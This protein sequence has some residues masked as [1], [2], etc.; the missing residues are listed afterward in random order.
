LEEL[1]NVVMDSMN[2]IG[3]DEQNFNPLNVA[4]L[5]EGLHRDFENIGEA[6]PIDLEGF[7]TIGGYDMDDSIPYD[8]CHYLD[9]E[10]TIKSI[11]GGQGGGAK[12]QRK[13]KKKKKQKGKEPS[14][15]PDEEEMESG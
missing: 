7:D 10:T 14:E 13:P 1:Q 11:V 3:D 5:L 6:G 9:F 8:E 4:H 15:T 12:K 2:S